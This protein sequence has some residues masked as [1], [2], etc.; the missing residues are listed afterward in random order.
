M[1]KQIW[2]HLWY[3]GLLILCISR[4]ASAIALVGDAICN[5]ISKSSDRAERT[6][7]KMTTIIEQSAC[8]LTMAS[9]QIE[10]QRIRFQRFLKYEISGR[11]GEMQGKF[12]F[13]KAVNLGSLSVK[14]IR[15]AFQDMD[16]KVND[17]AKKILD[18][19]QISAEEK[20]VA[21]MSATVA[22]LGFT[23]GTTYRNIANKI[24]QLGFDMCPA[25]IGPLLRL[26]HVKQPRGEILYIT[27][28]LEDSVDELLM[29]V[30]CANDKTLSLRAVQV[31]F[32]EHSD[33][34]VFVQ[35]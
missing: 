32:F 18:N 2:L 34:V 16:I 21:L 26:E 3:S 14:S 12:Q 4:V 28:N 35:R 11:L 9:Q 10:Y 1:S 13:L 15:E 30:A 24:S 17:A 19:M 29:T 22:E 33:I 20:R 23:E 5:A 7:D 27:T 31:G 25:E 6:T 8:K